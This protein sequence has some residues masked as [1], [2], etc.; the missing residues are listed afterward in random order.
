MQN[1]VYEEEKF[2]Q[3]HKRWTGGNE[4]IG[5]K[6]HLS[7]A[8]LSVICNFSSYSIATTGMIKK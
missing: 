2:K 8:D 7:Y 5:C 4:S 3:N 6:F 1:K